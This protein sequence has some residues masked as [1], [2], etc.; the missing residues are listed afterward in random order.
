M[1]HLNW[2]DGYMAIGVMLMKVIG[3][4]ERGGCDEPDV[5]SAR[6]KEDY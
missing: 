5:L 4:G 6:E 1:T 2:F 3:W